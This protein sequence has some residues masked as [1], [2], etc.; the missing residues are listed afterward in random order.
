[1]ASSRGRKPQLHASSSVV[2]ATADTVALGGS[3]LEKPHEIMIK[4]E[5]HSEMSEVG[6]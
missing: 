2:T 3:S 4:M 5:P 6:Q 1:M